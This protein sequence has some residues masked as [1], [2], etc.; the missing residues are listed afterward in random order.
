MYF[1][2]ST[3]TCQGCACG[4]FAGSC[5][6][7]TDDIGS[8]ALFGQLI[9]GQC[10]NV[11]SCSNGFIVTDSDKCGCDGIGC[12]ADPNTRTTTSAPN[13]CGPNDIL[14]FDETP[15]YCQACDC[16]GITSTLY[17]QFNIFLRF[18]YRQHI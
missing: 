9:I 4:T 8:N 2:D 15:G 17:L 12:K 10:P 18:C 11:A 6:P 13:N 5:V 16:T 14:G 1:D 3:G 7:I